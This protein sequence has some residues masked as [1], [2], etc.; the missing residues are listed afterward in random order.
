MDFLYSNT[1]NNILVDYIDNKFV[2][3]LDDRNVTL[4]YVFYIG[5]GTSSWA[6]KRQPIMMISLVE[7][8]YVVEITTTC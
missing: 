8:E 7:D 4:G 1:K 5:S 6:Y 2:G 3:S